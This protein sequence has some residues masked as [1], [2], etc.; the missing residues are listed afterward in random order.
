MAPRAFSLALVLP[1]ACFFILEGFCWAIVKNEKQFCVE[2]LTATFP[3]I[4]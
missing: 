2:G 4:F 1:V 3:A